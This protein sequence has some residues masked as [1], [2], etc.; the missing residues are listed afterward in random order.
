MYCVNMNIF[1]SIEFK[2]QRNKAVEARSWNNTPLVDFPLE[3]G[4]MN[5]SI[6]GGH[7]TKNCINIKRN[8]QNKI[9]TIIF[10]ELL[11]II[12]VQH[13]KELHYCSS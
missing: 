2:D 6:N 3:S 1:L 5:S 8:A 11:C 7:S 4:K 9:K 13:F 12:K 10:I